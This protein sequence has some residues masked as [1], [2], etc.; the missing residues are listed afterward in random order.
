MT[1]FLID[2]S[3]DVPG[4]EWELVDAFFKDH[5][6][7]VAQGTGSKLQKSRQYTIIQRRKGYGITS[8]KPENDTSKSLFDLATGP[9]TAI[10]WSWSGDGGRKFLCT[11]DKTSV[12]NIETGEAIHEQTWEHYSKPEDIPDSAF[13]GE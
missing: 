2:G 3:K 11:G 6:F 1:S 10:K 4:P 9:E 12:L 7:R 13:N 5:I 8:I